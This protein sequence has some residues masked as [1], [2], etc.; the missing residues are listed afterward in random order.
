LA[1]EKSQLLESSG[2]IGMEPS[3]KELVKRC[4]SGS[5]EAFE[6]LVDRYQKVVFNVAYRMVGDFDAAEDIT[7]SVFVKGFEKMTSYNPKFKFFSWLY[8]IAIN[9]SLN[10][11]KQQ[12]RMEALNPNIVSKEK[13]PE[14]Q[15]G[16]TEISRKV[17][18]A[19]M[20]LDPKYRI[21]LV[22]RHFRD[23]SYQEMSQVLQ[24]PEKTVKSRLFTARQ[25]LRS[26]LVER[27]IL[28]NE[29]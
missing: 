9:E 2:V 7:Q 6:T 16:E 3:D 1:K 25:L 21:V 28:G 17:E 11:I 18:E 20:G 4:L 24:I 13:S 29:G 23:C 5:E 19:L 12:K 14:Q 15:Y 10:H 8:R 22:L 27:G 26:L